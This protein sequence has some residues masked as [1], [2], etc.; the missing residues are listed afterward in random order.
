M[1]ML[2]GSLLLSQQISS[3]VGLAQAIWESKQ[4]CVN[5]STRSKQSKRHTLI[6]CR[7]TKHGSLVGWLQSDWPLSP[8]LRPAAPLEGTPPF[9]H[10]HRGHHCIDTAFSAACCVPQ[11]PRLICGDHDSEAGPQSSAGWGSIHSCQWYESASWQMPSA[12]RCLPCRRVAL[13]SAPLWRA[14][15][16]AA[17][18]AS[19]PPTRMMSSDDS[20][21]WHS[22]W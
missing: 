18:T 21:L 9:E 16:S 3:T 13:G 2:A 14:A 11:C 17:G 12:A 19:L 20:M 6:V 1:T 10:P 15:T 5:M 8:M 7:A 4:S 22:Y